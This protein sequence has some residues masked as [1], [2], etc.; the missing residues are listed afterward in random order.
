MKLRSVTTAAALL[1]LIAT[2][3][4][5]PASAAT[6]PSAIRGY[7]Q[8]RMVLSGSLGLGLAN[9]YGGNGSPLVAATAEFGMTPNISVGGSAGFASSK[10]GYADYTAKYTYT[11]VAARGSYH[12]TQVAPDKPLDVYAGLAL[13]YNHVGV[14]ET[15]PFAF[16]YSVGTSYALYGVYG[17]ARWWLNPR[18]A[19]F[20]ELGYGLGELALGASVRL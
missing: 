8:G 2:T 12:F 1:T 20:G 17:G 5:V 19:V 6:A 16:G 3:I 4:A 14:S 11:V 15:G 10:Y 13:G 18:T 9:T 7:E